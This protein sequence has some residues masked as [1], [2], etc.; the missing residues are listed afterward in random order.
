MGLI[1][2]LA[3]KCVEI[4]YYKHA[5]KRTHKITR[6][7]PH[8]FVGQWRGSVMA[9]Y[10]AST[11]RA[12]SVNY[13]IGC[14][15]D[16][17]CVCPED[18]HTYCSSSWSNDERAITIEIACDTFYPYA[19]EAKAINSL[20]NLMVDICQRHGLTEV[21]TPGGISAI[22]D[23]APVAVWTAH[24]WFDSTECP[25][26][27]LY[28]KRG[29]IAADV[30]YQLER[31]RDVMKIY[32]TVDDVPS[33]ARATIEKLVEKKAIQGTEPGVLNLSEDLVRLF[34]V[35]DRLGLYG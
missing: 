28:N 22:R 13:V 19:M 15:G 3:S 10:F 23:T 27:Y 6:I 24:R 26:D 16:I 7:T 33:W 21:S 1:S 2:P 31:S 5:G 12:I 4:P 20:V 18:I 9:D 30:N 8:C 32:R 11:P 34:V 25:G 17:V 29:K 35:H 14:D